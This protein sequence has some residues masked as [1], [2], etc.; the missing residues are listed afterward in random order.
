MSASSL[1]IEQCRQFW[2][3][4]AKDNGWY[5]EPFF[6][7]VWLDADGNVTDSVSHQGLTQDHVLNEEDE[8]L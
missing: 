4:I 5:K 2:A 3:K 8:V 1:T 6:V 7:Q